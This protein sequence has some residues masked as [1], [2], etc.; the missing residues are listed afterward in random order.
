MRP[1]RL[2]IEGFGTFRERTVIDFA[3][4]DLVAFVGPTGSGKSTIIDALTFALYGSVARYDN[5]SLVAPVIHQLATEA[6]VRLDFEVGGHRYVAVRVVR[7]MK[8]KPGAAPRATTREARL[9]RRDPTTP[10]DPADGATGTVLAGSVSELDEQVRDLLG[11]DFGQFTRTIVLPQGDFAEFLKDDPGSRQKLLRRL[12]DLDIYARMGSTARER[13]AA[14]G[15]QAT[16]YGHELDRLA[17]VTPDRLAAAERQAKDLAELTAALPALVERVATV[18]AALVERRHQVTALD[19]Q[20]A[21]LADIVVPDGLDDVGSALDIA[22][23]NAERATAAVATARD[24]RDRAMGEAE[25]AGEPANL[26][27]LLDQHERR[28]DVAAA[29]ETDEADLAASRAARSALDDEIATAEQRV[30]ATIAAARAARQGADATPWIERLVVGE[31]CP[32]CGQDV[33]DRPPT[34][35]PE[36]VDVAEEAVEAAQRQLAGV[37]S[38]AATLDGRL[39]SLDGSLAERRSALTELDAALDGTADIETVRSRL[40]A[41]N[42]ARTAATEAEAAARAVEREAD[43]ATRRLVELR[44]DSEQFRSALTTT[45]DRVADLGPPVPRELSLLADWRALAEWAGE[46]VTAL[47]AQRREIADDGRRLAGTKAELVAELAAAVEPHGIAPDV[48]TVAATVAAAQA[49]A[50]AQVES[51]AERLAHKR[52]LAATKAELEERRVVHDDLGRKHLSAGGFERWLLTEAL[53]DIVA[54]ATVR[55][56]ELSNGRYS[57]EATDG[58]FAV[59]DHGNADERRDVRTLS[60][61][62]VFLASLAL[63]LALA[64]S[65]AELAPVDSPRLESIFLDEGFGTLDPETLDVLASAIEE[66]SA[67]G[68]LVAIVT[69]VRDL[70]ERMPVRFE[71]RKG[72]TTS[73]VE[74]AEP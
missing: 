72:V 60:G 62:E 61:G 36:V 32:I 44:S 47:E 11:L 65:I 57:L 38:E 67:T 43:A 24:A 30:A 23:E 53:D 17:N 51:L 18:E 4:L 35:G 8:S 73:T 48:E 10:D 29:S 27:R 26:H 22:A 69:H 71:V 31:P 70:A 3:D 19:A 54:R 14:A 52:E 34:A 50:E 15:Q 68:R 28:A 59:C 1:V 45:R 74:R 56:Y 7:R 39:R 6:K 20:L 63:A 25:Q 40:V 9:E 55:L 64:D 33:H 37:T 42:D 21:K 13:A 41:A 46:R 49:R 2:E 58:S 5:P 16:V 12:L 66:L